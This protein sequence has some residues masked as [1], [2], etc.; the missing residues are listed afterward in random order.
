MNLVL[1][2]VI[3]N[4]KG[5][6]GEF[7]L[8]NLPSTI[9]SLPTNS[10][11]KIGFSADFAQ[12]YKL[13][14]LKT[15]ANR[16]VTAKIVGF[17]S[18]ETIAELKEQGIF[19]DLSLLIKHNPDYYST[20]EVVGSKVFDCKSSELIGEIIEVWE[21]PANDVW[22]VETNDGFLPVP[23]ID[24]VVLKYDFLNKRV[25]I[26]V[27]DGLWDIMERKKDVSI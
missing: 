11:I 26:N 1:L 24:E 5:V 23:F 21:M 10:P 20:D 8:H 16:K 9:K 25:E 22:L 4:S 6:S 19:I 27:L 17:D 18:K 14:W 2:G 3:G 12:Q 15:A 7:N 13:E